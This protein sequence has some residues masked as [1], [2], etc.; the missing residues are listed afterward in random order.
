MA[1]FYDGSGE[2]NAVMDYKNPEYDGIFCGGED[3]GGR[4]G[5]WS[6]SFSAVGTVV[7]QGMYATTFSYV[8]N[9]IFN[10]AAHKGHISGAGGAKRYR[11]ELGTKARSIVAPGAVMSIC[12]VNEDPIVF[13]DPLLIMAVEETDDEYTCYVTVTSTLDNDDDIDMDAYIA[14]MPNAWGTGS[15]VEGTNNGAVG[16]TSHAMGVCNVAVGRSSLVFGEFCLIEPIVKADGSNP[17]KKGTDE[18]RRGRY[19]LTVGNGTDNTARS[20]AYTL[21]W[22]GNGWFAGTAEASALILRSSTEGSRKKFRITVDDTGALTAEQISGG[23]ESITASTAA[24]SGVT[25]T[26]GLSG[27]DAWTVS[28]FAH[29]ISN[30][31]D[32]SG[33]TSEV[34]VDYDG[35][36]R[37]VS[38]GDQVTLSLANTDYTFDV[39]GFNHDDLTDTTAYGET[40]AT[41]KAGI[42]FQ[43]H[44]CFATTYTM[45]F[46]LSAGWKDSAMRNNW[47]RIMEGYL[48]VAWQ[49]AIKPVN[50]A[51]G[52]GG[53]F[54]S[55]TETV[56]DSC[57]LLSEIEIFGSTTYSVSGEGAQYAYY[58]AGNSKVKNRSGSADSWWERSPFV[59]RGDD[60]CRVNSDGSAFTGEGTVKYGVAFGFCV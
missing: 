52:T 9:S 49:T 37:K 36:H 18:T 46:F 59:G 26:N 24:Q 29:A 22:D 6:T 16:S 58:K 50:K 33:T 5:N 10:Q 27:L 38:V 14:I 4:A 13:K 15:F 48:P 41:G 54:S 40:T 28:E 53:G 7:P 55:G 25:Y 44:D 60:F 11:V 47:M 23:F 20:N 19:V 42:T 32:I 8:T 12:P 45:D 34:Y 17:T 31:S 21:D 56:S 43:M 30:N 2:E 35:K 57:F 51:S 3:F 1:T 39:I